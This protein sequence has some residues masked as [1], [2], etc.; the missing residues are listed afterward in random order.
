MP[1]KEPA[2]TVEGEISDV[3]AHRFVVRTAEGS[4][5]ADLG[6]KGAKKADVKVGDK[7]KLTGRQTP[8]EL[9]VATFERGGETIAVEGPDGHEDEHEEADPAAALKAVKDLGHEVV[10]EPR[11]KPKH[12][13]VLAKDGKGAHHEHHVA[14]DGEIKKTKAGDPADDKWKKSKNKAKAA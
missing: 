14:H 9:K 2:A 12:F 3:F 13:E 4:V 1:H 7:V 11:R 8:S 5:M 10:G 6:P